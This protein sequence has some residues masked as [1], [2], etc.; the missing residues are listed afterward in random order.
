MA[1]NPTIQ[2]I[3][4]MLRKGKTLEEGLIVGESLLKLAKQG[5]RQSEG[6]ALFY[7]NF[8]QRKTAGRPRSA[9]EYYIPNAVEEAAI[10]DSLVKYLQGE[11][12]S[13]QRE[14]DIPPLPSA[15]ILNFD[16]P[17]VLSCTKQEWSEFVNQLDLGQPDECGCRLWN[18]DWGQAR[19][20]VDYLI[21][22]GIVQTTHIGRVFLQ[23]FHHDG[24][25]TDNQA[26][27]A[28]SRASRSIGYKVG[29]PE[30]EDALK[31]FTKNQHI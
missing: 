24:V 11:I 16:M 31:I 20:V 21:N 15:E 8:G 1:E 29:Y 18:R 25:N 10:R 22:N 2:K 12:D 9:D 23:L 5:K 6:Y 28:L 13:I 27:N 7:S 4:D 17:E 19:K 3:T 30:I 14:L 26:E